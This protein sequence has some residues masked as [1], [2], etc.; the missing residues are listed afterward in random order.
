[1]EPQLRQLE[2]DLA[3]AQ[4]RYNQAQRAQQSALQ[5]QSKFNQSPG[6][7]KLGGDG[8][9]LLRI[10]GE[11]T[12]AESQLKTLRPQMDQSRARLAEINRRLTPPAPADTVARQ[13]AADPITVAREAAP[14]STGVL[15][16]TATWWKEYWMILTGVA[17]AALWLLSRIMRR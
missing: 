13:G 8:S 2:A 1:L 17:L 4:Q 7:G 12:F 6:S 10:R 9:N 5:S 15:Q 16:D 3:A 11:L 14:P